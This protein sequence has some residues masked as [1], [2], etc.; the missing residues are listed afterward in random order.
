MTWQ[1]LNLAAPEYEKP[2]EPPKL[3]GLIYAGKRHLISGL[4]E[5]AK[6]LFVLIVGLEHLRTT[7]DVFALIDFESGPEATRRMLTDLGATLDE[8]GRV[9]YVDADAP[10]DTS[11]LDALA[12]AGVTL[13][14]I[15]AAVGAYDVSGLDDNHR[16]DAESFGRAWIDPLWRRGIASVLVDH[17]VKN[18]EAR[19]KFAIGSERKAG[20]VDVH[21][22]LEAVTQLSRGKTGLIRIITHK[23]RPAWLPRPRAAELEL[24]S[25]P[26]TH[27]LTWEFK[28]AVAGDTDS[29]S[30]RPTVLMERV[31]DFLREQTEPIGRNAIVSAVSGK[32]EYVLQAI[33]FLVLEDVANERKGPRG[34]KLVALSDRF[35]VPHQSPEPLGTTEREPVAG[36]SRRSA[37]AQHERRKT[38][39]QHPR[40]LRSAGLFTRL[41]RRA[42]TARPENRPSR[43]AHHGSSPRA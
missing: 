9:Y 24:N 26:D 13:A 28:P 43:P 15:D 29:A 11:D 39:L 16:K 21:L 31:T 35:P 2:S 4:P 3:C 34:A 40:S 27:A 7:G 23:D 32:R 18:S 36:T 19:G 8:I 30:W 10:P 1:P 41:L 5:A 20:R 6:T 38:R 37:E 42:R 17:V 25:D 33:D 22:G 12:A 14:L